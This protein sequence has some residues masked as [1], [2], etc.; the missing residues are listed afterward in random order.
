MAG[1]LARWTNRWRMVMVAAPVEII[2]SILYC[3]IALFK[4]E[5]YL[6]NENFLFTFP[7]CFGALYTINNL[8]RRGNPRR[9]YYLSGLSV[10][11]FWFW[12]PNIERSIYWISLIISQLFVFLS[13]REWENKA[14]I[15][16]V[17]IYC[18][19]MISALCLATVALVL[20]IVIYYSIVYIF[21]LE[22]VK[23]W[24]FV[25]YTIRVTYLLLAPILF[26]MFNTKQEEEWETGRFASV[27]IHYILSPALLVYT[28]VLYLYII[29]IVGIWSLPK[30]GV[31]YMVLGF[32]TSMFCVKSVQPLLKRRYFDWFYG[33][34][35]WWVAPTLILL[36]VGTM[37]R[38]QEY[39]FTE[40][41]FYLLLITIIV[42]LTCGMF[43]TRR[44]S[45]Y[46]WVVTGTLGMLILFS[47]IPGIQARDFGLRSQIARVERISKKLG[48]SDG[49]QIHRPETSLKNDSIVLRQYKML[50]DA[51]RY[52]QKEEGS[53]YVK[54]RFGYTQAELKDQIIPDEIDEWSYTYRSVLYLFI[55]D[56]LPVPVK[57]YDLF[58]KVTAYSSGN[59]IFYSVTGGELI[60]QKA[61]TI[62]VEKNLTEWFRN[63]LKKN[64]ITRKE[65]LTQEGL[66]KYLSQFMLLDIAGIRIVFNSIT[67]D[68]KTAEVTDVGIG[69]ILKKEK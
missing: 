9:F 52:V 57:G 14:F 26:L 63:I 58:E 31:A 24:L 37:Y 12:Q 36:W 25:E 8:T 67:V 27:L 35:S 48:I 62:L 23:E 66:A 11:L 10:I 13:W 54:K 60:L 17:F 29:K 46:A 47:Y 6:G 50:Y 38:I 56:S 40:A 7:V 39:G 2:I 59:N 53:E 18:K 22:I 20:A 16:A 69:F 21:D 41:R 68:Q 61:D 49:K 65:E 45:R 51:Y 44:T 3:F 55:P 33:Y 15:K 1:K 30:G 64:G 28:F 34:F 43:F 5:S 19:D 42:T 4:Y 32:V